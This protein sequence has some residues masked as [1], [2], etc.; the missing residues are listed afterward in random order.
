MKQEII[1]NNSQTSTTISGW[2]T[3]FLWV[4]VGLGAVV[5]C[6]RNIVELTNIGWTPLSILIF[7]GY[8]GSMVIAAVLT[9]IAFYQRKPNAVSLAVTYIAMIALDGI[10]QIAM[11]TVIV[12]DS[13][14][15]DIIRPF[16]WATIWFSYLM[17]SKQVKELIPTKMRRWMPIEK[18]LL[19]VYVGSSIAL[20]FGFKKISE[21]P[22][23]SHMITKEYMIQLVVAEANSTLP[24]D[25]EEG[26]IW[27]KI[28]IEGK[29][30]NYL[31]RFPNLSI[32]N[33]NLNFLRMHGV[34]HRQELLQSYA[35]ETDSDVIDYYELLFG[36]GYNICYTIKDKDYQVIY[37]IVNTPDDYA[38]AV[39][40]TSNFKCERSAWNTLIS[41]TNDELPIICLGDCY[42]AQVTVNFEKNVLR[43]DVELPPMDDISVNRLITEQYIRDFI[44]NNDVSDYL[45]RMAT[46][47]R[48]DIQYHFFTSKGRDHITVSFTPDQYAQT[49]S[50]DNVSTPNLA[51]NEVYVGQ[52]NIPSGATTH[53]KTRLLQTDDFIWEGKN[54]HNEVDGR[55]ILTYKKRTSIKGWPDKIAEEGDYIE[56]RFENGKPVNANW[57]SKDGTKKD[58]LLGS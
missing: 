57:F 5:G 8:L 24:L 48:M 1:Q 49:Q 55:G 14:A 22:T 43:Y 33:L 21:D 40:A 30:I 20:F 34:A 42:L 46:I 38:Y 56:G 52:N 13:G 53:T 12:D 6:V 23:H 11:Y 27:E 39:A 44:R 54:N 10:L 4:G 41:Q 29:N 51:L 2:L 16:V 45:W 31:Y 50:S 3:F 47:D 15:W 25:V 32:E 35:L 18:I 28:E 9:I 58:F 37:S 36:N 17:V 26:F 7:T 19:V